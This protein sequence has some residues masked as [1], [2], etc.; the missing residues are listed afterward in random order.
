[1]PASREIRT[2]C[3]RAPPTQ[4]FPSSLM[5]AVEMN[6]ASNPFPAKVRRSARGIPGV[7][8]A[9][10]AAVAMLAALRG[11]GQPL[12]GP[13]VLRPEAF[14]HYFERFNQEDRDR[15]TQ[16]EYIKD[17]RAWSFL[18][19]QVPLLDCPDPNVEEIY[20]FR[21]W[22]YRKHIERIPSGFVITEFLPPVPW[23]GRYDTISCAA[24]FHIEEGRWLHDPEYVQD[25]LDFWFHGGGAPR[26]YSCW[27]AFAAWEDYLV[28]GDRKFVVGLLPALIAN[29][30]AWERAHQDPNGLFWQTDDRDGMEMSIGGSGYRETI[31][32]YMYGD[33]LAISRLARLAGRPDLASAFRLKA[34]RIK[35]MVEEKLWDPSA[36]FFK[37]A[38]RSATIRLVR[39]REEQGYT[40][41]FFD[42][43]DPGY[44]AAWRQIADPRGFAAP[45]GPTTAEQRDPDFAIR[46]TGHECQWNG[47]SWPFATSV[48]LTAMANLLNDYH[49][50]VLTKRT[51]FDLLKTY[52][53]S[54]HLRTP[55]GG[56]RPWIGE[57]LDPYNGDWIARRL[58]RER[59]QGPPD[60]GKDYNHSKYADLIITG[61]IGLRPRANDEIVVNP[62]VPD[63]AWGWFCLDNI[64]YHGRVLTILYDRTGR[65]YGR[66]AGLQILADGRTVAR[67]D[68]LGKLVASLGS[69]R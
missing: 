23:A 22:S 26:L 45:F 18:R 15:Y 35:R 42:L 50:R 6:S 41:W 62:L 64:L 32:S 36:Q 60:R 7:A 5:P 1:M 49:Q 31:N 47:P 10:V 20:Y 48:T 57:D 44:A 3:D 46:L 40:P 61:L 38:P 65:H 53:R 13:A 54:Q 12:P 24:G 67:S 59:R 69:G 2:R 34:A 17:P 63:G 30:R 21:W 19:N 33:A 25:Y 9:G 43:P 16:V 58:L 55:Q 8:R 27:L 51:Y 11:L 68:R 52:T 66:G 4:I 37:V 39:V 28:T 29:Y 14:A 56:S